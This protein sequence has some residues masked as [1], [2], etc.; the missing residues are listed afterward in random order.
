MTNRFIREFQLIEFEI[1]SRAGNRNARQFL[2]REAA[3]YD[4]IVRENY[5]LLEYIRKL[6]NLIQHPGHNTDGHAVCISDGFFAEVQDIRKRL[7][8]PLQAGSVGVPRECV[9]IARCTDRLGDLAEE[10][11]RER[12]THVPIVDERNVILG[13]FNEAALFDYL[14]SEA[15]TIIA[16]DMQ[17]SEV[18]RHCQPDA[19]HT[20]TFIFVS[21]QTPL[22]DLAKMFLRVETWTMR[23]GVVFVT[24]SGKADE[25]FQRLI[26]PW[27][28]LEKFNVESADRGK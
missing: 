3:K 15:E 1:N 22:Y 12:F 24:A 26:T 21:P 27:D 25:S 2:L 8:N 18:F 7:Q 11:K 6:R 5:V 4:N 19:E 28:V 10:M 17:I 20:E 23:V 13:V 14:W 16:R 9:K